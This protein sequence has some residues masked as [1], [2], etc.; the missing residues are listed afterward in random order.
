MKEILAKICSLENISAS[1]LSNKLNSSRGFVK[2][3]TYK[4]EDQLLYKLLTLFPN[5]NPYFLITGKG[6]MTVEMTGKD[7]IAKMG[8]EVTDYHLL[9]DQ[10]KTMYEDVAKQNAHLTKTVRALLDSQDALLSQI[11]KD[12]NA[13][14]IEQ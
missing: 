13:Q 12:R 7:K 4:K 5:L 10:M 8:K 3:V 11:E 2:S 1:A 6:P 9:Y 14:N